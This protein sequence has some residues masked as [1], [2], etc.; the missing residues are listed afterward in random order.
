MIQ[1]LPTWYCRNLNNSKVFFALCSR[2][3]KACSSMFR[4]WKVWST[5]D[6]MHTGRDLRG[7]GCTSR[8]SMVMLLCKPTPGQHPHLGNHSLTQ[9]LPT[10]D[11]KGQTTPTRPSPVKRQPLLPS[12]P[13]HHSPLPIASWQKVENTLPS[14]AIK[15]WPG[16]KTV[17][18]VVEQNHKLANTSRVSTLAVRIAR[19]AVYG[20]KLMKQCTVF[21]GRDLP[22][23]PREEL[24]HLKKV[25]FDLFP[26]FW[27]NPEDFESVWSGCIDAIGQACKRLRNM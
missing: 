14:S 27:K 15:D 2:H 23:L 13:S 26:A 8:V 3:N 6:H 5:V 19:E 1:H 10:P 11:P 12:L 17:K 18:V 7:R 21:G 22:G 16:K 20:E 24:F 25:I 9:P 4:P